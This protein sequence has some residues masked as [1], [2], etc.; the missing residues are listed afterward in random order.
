[1]TTADNI[2]TIITFADKVGVA[3]DVFLIALCK[4]DSKEVWEFLSPDMQY[5]LVSELSSKS[6]SMGDLLEMDSEYFFIDSDI[7]LRSLNIV[8]PHWTHK[9]YTIK[10]WESM[11]GMALVDWLGR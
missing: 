8:S 9:L 5:V 7:F 4:A 3:E 1:M 10:E 6:L 11:K 2:N